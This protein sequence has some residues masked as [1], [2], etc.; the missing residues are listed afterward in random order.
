MDWV[1]NAAEKAKLKIY[2]K[3]KMEIAKLCILIRY[4]GVWLSRHLFAVESFDWL[5]DIAKY[6]S[7]LVFNRYGD[8]PEV[9]MYFHPHYGQ[10]FHWSYDSHS[11]TKNM[12]NIALDSFFIAAQP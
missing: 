12:Y 2:V 1:K 5:I 8:L 9:V 11:N 10:P 6:P 4:G 7:Q 3:D